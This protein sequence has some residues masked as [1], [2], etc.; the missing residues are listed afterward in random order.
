MA[1][2]QDEPASALPQ[3]TLGERLAKARHHAGLEQGDLAQRLKVSRQTI[4]FWETGRTRPRDFMAV[5]RE[6]S[7]ATHVPVGWLLDVDSASCLSSLD[8]QT[9]FLLPDGREAFDFLR[10]PAGYQNVA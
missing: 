6:W 4:G 7:E 5:I 8:D 10:H 1:L 2:A 9:S 3:W